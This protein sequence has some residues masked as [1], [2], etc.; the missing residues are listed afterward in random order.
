MANNL[1]TK[2][3]ANV[4]TITWAPYSTLPPKGEDYFY[5]LLESRPSYEWA[6]PDIIALTRV[7][8]W[9]AQADEYNYRLE[10]EGLTLTNAKGTEVLNPVFSAVDQLERRIVSVM[11]KLAIF[12]ISSNTVGTKSTIGDRARDALE[13]KAMADEDKED[14]D[15]VG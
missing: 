13:A 5:S 15:L 1:S 7:A 12:R 14:G 6:K 8:G 10:M 2:K 9:L 3:K 4:A 11:A